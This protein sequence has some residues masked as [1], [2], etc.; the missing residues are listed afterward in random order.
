[1]SLEEQYV[2]SVCHMFARKSFKAVL[3]HMSDHRCEPGINFV[4]GI[5]SCRQ[6]Y[7]NFDSY[8]RHMY[9]KHRD[10][11]VARSEGDADQSA[12]SD[13]N[14]HVGESVETGRTQVA[15]LPHAESRALFSKK[16]SALFLL[17][18]REERKVTQTAL[19][20][21]IQDM[22]GFWLEAVEKIQVCFDNLLLTT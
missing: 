4:C 6:V 15:R 17:K 13:P 12:C 22:N 21:I 14:S 1:M 20:G 9:R 2:C 7:E 5:D 16:S 11:L 8:R 3:R 19:N 10:H 18:T